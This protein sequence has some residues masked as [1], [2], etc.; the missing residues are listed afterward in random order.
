M[1]IPASVISNPPR[2]VPAS[3]QLVMMFGGMLSKFGWIFGGFGMIFLLLFA[4]HADFSSWTEFHGALKT[5]SGMIVSSEK[6]HASEGGGNHRRGNP[7]YAYHYRFSVNGTEY[8]GTAYAT[9]GGPRN[10]QAVTVEFPAGKPDISRIQGMRRA[11]FGPEVGFVVIFPLIGLAIVLA[12]LRTNFRNLTLLANGETAQARITG[13]EMTKT[14]VNGRMV[15]KVWFEFF[16]RTGASQK[17][18]TRTNAPEKLAGRVFEELFYD[19][20]RPTRAILLHQLPGSVTLDERGQ[21]KASGTGALW[22][23]LWAPALALAFMA[24]A[25]CL[26]KIL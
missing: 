6:T 20:N 10:H 3:T 24:T 8:H 4:S 9:G 23:A 22:G 1:D 26:N 16:D 12:S 18:F 15:Y 11:M 17:T 19:A 2:D 14:R 25:I 13:K 7:I 5:A 21:V